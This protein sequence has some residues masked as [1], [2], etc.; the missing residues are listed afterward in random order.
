[1]E[2]VPLKA[3]Q[4]VEMRQEVDQSAFLE[5]STQR[6]I[7]PTSNPRLHLLHKKQLRSRL[8]TFRCKR[9]CKMCSMDT[10][11]LSI[12]IFRPVSLIRNLIHL[13][14]LR[15][16]TNRHR[17]R[18]LPLEAHLSVGRSTFHQLVGIPFHLFRP[19]RPN[20]CIMDLTSHSFLTTL[21][22]HL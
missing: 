13:T 21:E 15:L 22:C 10:H 16:F 14:V 18:A 5:R 3:G 20:Q 11:H 9:L 4:G 2:P 6:R 17:G 1:M 7:P 8:S 19:T 12:R